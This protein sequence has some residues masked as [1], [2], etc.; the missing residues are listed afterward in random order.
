MKNLMLT[1]ISLLFITP[2]L[3]YGWVRPNPCHWGIS[4]EYLYLL[5]MISESF[6]AQQS[7]SN[8]ALAAGERYNN[9]LTFTSAYRLTAMY[10]LG[11]RFTDFQLIWTHLPKLS[12]TTSVSGNLF[13]IRNSSNI[14]SARSTIDVG[15]YSLEGIFG[16][17]GY[18]S[19]PIDFIFHTGVHYT[20]LDF[21]ETIEY[22]IVESDVRR[23]SITQNRSDIWGIGPEI[24]FALNYPFLGNLFCGRGALSF[25]SDVK[26]ALLASRYQPRFQEDISFSN[27]EKRWGLVPFWDI[28]LGMS[29]TMSL[30][31]MTTSLEIGYEMIYYHNAIDRINFENSGHSFDLY[32]D[33]NF[34]G[35]Y[36]ALGVIF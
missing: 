14:T 6:Y 34:Q 2:S 1:V 20:N 27:D 32:S 13:A 30:S 24:A 15:F 8:G 31:C 36:I 26:G 21:K 10:A 11:N 23:I 35:P 25:C 28:R 18:K 22:E 3:T 33:A 5:P 29:Y 4:G 19:N 7:N 12:H 9:D 16:V 17:W